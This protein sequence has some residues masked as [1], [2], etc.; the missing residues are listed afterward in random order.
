AFRLRNLPRPLPRR[1]NRATWC[2]AADRQ[3]AIGELHDDCQLALDPIEPEP[4]YSMGARWQLETTRRLQLELRRAA[5]HRIWNA[6]RCRLRGQRVTPRNADPRPEC[7]RVRNELPVV[8]LRWPAAV[9]C[10]VPAAVQRIRQ[11]PIH[12]I[13]QQ[14]ELQRT[15]GESEQA[16]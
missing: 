6:A 14:F 11:H 10:R 12:G 4:E 13:R 15:T 1:S 2:V 7:D 16:A 8:E 3:H 9:A 5:G